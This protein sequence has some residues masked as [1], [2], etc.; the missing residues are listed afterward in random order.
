MSSVVGYPVSEVATPEATPP[1]Y[2]FGPVVDFVCL[3]GASL[4][5]LPLIVWMFPAH[6][7]RGDVLVWTLLL[8]NVI[9]HPHFA[10]SYQLFY[11][12]FWG[13]AFGATYEGAF[14]W[15]Y[16]AAAMLVPLVLIAFFSWCLLKRD[17]SSLA[18][19][20]NVMFFLVGW[21]YVKQGYGML[22]LDSVLKRR[23]L[24]EQQ[25]KRVLYNGYVCW[26]LSW[27]LVN[28]LVA[29]GNYFGLKYYMLPMP[30]LVLY[31]ASA[32]AAVTTW[33]ALPVLSE[34]V[35]AS[36]K[37]PAWNGVLAYVASLYLWLLV[38]EPV[39]LLVVPAFHSLQYLVVVWRYR[40]NFETA[41]A[42]RG[43][44]RSTRRTIV[45]RMFSFVLAGFTL[46]YLAFWFVPEY[47]DAWVPY[48][49]AVFGSGLFLFMFWIF[50]N[51]HHYFLDSVLWRKENTE[52]KRHLF[53]LN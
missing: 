46:G 30:E 49:R 37:G 28:W 29:E 13:K 8:A 53:S 10:H 24:S 22:I 44:N 42:G 12:G 35:R 7:Y 50:I 4:I 47:L 1:R 38:R 2:L 40:L 15:R 9:N 23:Y 36:E 41:R 26:L 39:L 5:L 48:D 27:M 43:V 21:H 45:L 6:L 20:A 14:Q 17:V 16:R 51:V 18:L 33:R 32:M 52:T 34:L 19:G 25:K 31:C 3:G 11:R